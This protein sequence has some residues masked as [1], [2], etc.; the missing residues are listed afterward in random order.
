ML[1]IEVNSERWLNPENLPGEKWQKIHSSKEYGRLYISTYGRLKRAKFSGGRYHWPEMIFRAHLSRDNGYYRVRVA[2]KMCAVHRLVAEAF[3]PNLNNYPQV[4][5]INRIKTDNRVENLRWAS[6]EMNMAN[7]KRGL[8]RVACF[9]ALGKFVRQWE[10]IG[11]AA[12]AVGVSYGHMLKV[13]KENEWI[14][15]Y[16]FKIII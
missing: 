6:R 13:A 11:E 16:K 14:G 2:G 1:E 5:H 15:N 4:D 3:L 7:T 12:K 8:L 10:R 9:N